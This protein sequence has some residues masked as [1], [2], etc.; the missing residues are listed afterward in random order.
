[1]TFF[2]QEDLSV[3]GYYYE[4]GSLCGILHYDLIERNRTLYI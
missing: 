4:L 3:S 2:A 1:M